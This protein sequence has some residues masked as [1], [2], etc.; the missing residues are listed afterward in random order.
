MKTSIDLILRK[1]CRRPFKVGH[2]TARNCK[3]SIIDGILE[4][5]IVLKSDMSI[6]MS[7]EEQPAVRYRSRKPYDQ[8]TVGTKTH[9]NV[10]IW[11]RWT[12]RWKTVSANR[13]LFRNSILISIESTSESV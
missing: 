1:V 12:F 4:T 10:H 5:G 3:S 8:T 6:K 2:I 7:V 9:R 13:F 11:L